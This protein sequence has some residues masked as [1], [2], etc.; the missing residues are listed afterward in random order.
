MKLYASRFKIK[1][2]SPPAWPKEAYHPWRILSVVYAVGGGGGVPVVVPAWRGEGL[3]SVL[4]MVKG[5]GRVLTGEPYFPLFWK[6]PETKDQD[7]PSPLL[8]G[9]HL[10]KQYLPSFFGY[11]R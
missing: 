2:E 8:T 7:T 11:R 9:T 3:P 10:L 6:G 4:V 1:Q 5:R